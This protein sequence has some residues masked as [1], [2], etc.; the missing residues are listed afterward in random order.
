MIKYK[1]CDFFMTRTPFASVNDYLAMFD[2]DAS[3]DLGIRLKEAFENS[4]LK[5]ALAIASDDLLKAASNSDLVAKRKSSNQIRSSLVKYFIRL[6][7]RP[8]P[9]GLFS[10]I[11][12][13]KFGSVSN[14]TISD[15]RRHIK[16]A[17]LD[18]EWIYGIIKK[19]EADN[20]IRRH[21]GVRFNDF[22]FANGSRI[23]KPNKTFLQIEES[24]NDVP[25]LSTSIRYTGQVKAI[26][27][28]CSDFHSFSVLLDNI[29]SQNHTV[30]VEKIETFLSQLLENE[31]LLSK[32]RPPLIN[33]DML[34]YILHVLDTIKD[35]EEVS[36]YVQNLKEIQKNIV[37][38]NATPI[39]ERM[40]IYSE[41]IRLQKEL[42]ECKNYLQVDMKTHIESNVLDLNSK[43]E[44]E[45]FVSAMLRIAPIEKTSDEMTRYMELFLERYGHSAEVPLLE[46][47][48]VD[49]GLGTPMHFQSDK[50]NHIVPKRQEHIKE[51]RIS[52]LLERKL[53]LAL[54]EGKKSIAITESDIDHICKDEVF[55]SVNHPMNCSQSFELYLL[56][57]L[58]YDY[59]FTFLSMSEGFGKT[60][61]RFS[62]LLTADEY[63][64]LKEGFDENKNLYDEYIVV[65]IAELP[66]SGRVSNV[67]INNSEYD[68]QIALTTTP[69]KGKQILSIRDV[70]IGID[71]MRN[72]FYIKS[73]S[74]DKKLIVT[75]TS[76]LNPMH[77]SNS[78]R[79]LTEISTV[80]K[81]RISDGIYSIIGTPYEYS[82]RITYGKIIIKPETW[83]ISKDILGVTQ[84]INK[85]LSN[86]AI[87]ESFEHFRQKWALP[88]YVFLNE[89][90]NRLL[91]DLDNLDHRNEVYNVLRKDL[92]MPATLTELTCDFGEHVAANADG[93]K[94]ITEIVVPFL[95]AGNRTKSTTKATE[96]SSDKVLKT[97]SNVSANRM[98]INREQ[99]MLLPGNN[100]W[101]YYKLYGCSKRQDELIAETYHTL[102]KLVS[103]GLAQK[104]F[105]IRYSDPEPHLRLRIQP[106]ENGMP[107]L[108]VALGEWISGLYVD[109]IISKAVNDSYIRESERYGGPRLI[110]YA[111]DYFYHDSKLSMTL[112]F[113]QR[114]KQQNLIMDYI[115]IS[116]IVSALE[117][118]GLI[119][120]EQEIF[121][122]S[123]TDKKNYRKEFQKDRLMI[124]R[125]VDSSDDWF[126]I[127]SSISN[128]EVY[129][130]INSNAQELKKYA[131]SIFESDQ[132]GELTN[133]IQSIVASIIHMFC[134]RIKGD[135]AWE[136]KMY[137]LTAFGVRSLNGFLKHNSKK[138]LILELPD[139]L[140]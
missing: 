117:A 109:G 64:L 33:T 22:T 76:M 85:K 49:K 6:S 128:P 66:A 53:L 2:D 102:E 140:I 105:Y 41:T 125:A 111:E 61:G 123:L 80:R 70:Y 52:N 60:F 67:S 8:T 12:I 69:C 112:L 86:D 1:A 13:G 7:T 29:I 21:L 9:F 10:G 72:Q 32:L 20:N 137:A 30:P 94:F 127:R 19:M 27:T 75:M 91:L 88:R 124:M 116:F 54:R 118:F 138:T 107:S 130:L 73:K 42:H 58:G 50:I 14:I 25:E 87:K 129:K 36:L 17:R 103:G 46:L 37:D 81:K 4:V 77:S 18:M 65:E 11:S 40:D 83:V 114:F 78:L 115:G 74:L 121:L 97:L 110:Q 108:F 26:E 113:R 133:P 45:Q 24:S 47:L 95:L 106:T 89:G 31:Y 48:D 92:M 90:D 99:L 15:S 132:R 93:E 79:F 101:L 139:S 122:E 96:R 131:K 100:E 28:K 23:E 39:G 62:D 3:Y 119:L 136:Q 126:D 84:D 16:R 43:A 63:H 68:Y 59:S 34:V 82:P 55:D 35:V 56:P 134:N 38:Y 5:E 98:N 120:D 57:H 135:S 71:P 51:Q 44:L 104:Y